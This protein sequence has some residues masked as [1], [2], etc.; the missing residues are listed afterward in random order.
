MVVCIASG[1]KGTIEGGTRRKLTFASLVKGWPGMPQ[2]REAPLNRH[3]KREVYSRT[4]FGCGWGSSAKAYSGPE[5]AIVCLANEQTVIPATKDSA[6][7][8]WAKQ[9]A[10][11]H[12]G[13]T[14]WRPSVLDSTRAGVVAQ[15][16]PSWWLRVESGLGIR[17]GGGQVPLFCPLFSVYSHP[18]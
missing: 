14:A 2:A 6:G 7:V 12:I 3:T 4:R 18:L 9:H 11:R 16:R 17:G 8:P 10:A 15:G 1:T 5:A 13:M